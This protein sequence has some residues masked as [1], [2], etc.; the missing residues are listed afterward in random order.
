MTS[1][2]FVNA[3][4]LIPWDCPCCGQGFPVC[5]DALVNEFSKPSR[6]KKGSM[7]KN[8]FHGLCWLKVCKKR[9]EHQQP[10]K[11]GIRLE[12]LSREKFLLVRTLSFLFVLLI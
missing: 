2:W 5:K 1:K 6:S 8:T 7:H 9:R 3:G 12:T 10:W 11:D 4:A